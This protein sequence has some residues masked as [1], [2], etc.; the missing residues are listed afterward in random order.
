MDKLYKS[1]SNSPILKYILTIF[2]HR[3]QFFYLKALVPLTQYLTIILQGMLD[4][5]RH[6]RSKNRLQIYRMKRAATTVHA[7]I[8]HHRVIRIEEQSAE[9]F[10]QLRSRR[11]SSDSRGS[12]PSRLLRSA[13]LSD[14]PVSM[15]GVTL[16]TPSACT[17]S[18]LDGRASSTSNRTSK[19]AMASPC[20]TR[21]TIS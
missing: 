11:V 7:I 5:T 3:L 21:I 16:G 14:Q 4:S 2:L 13:G 10:D 9:L 19:L 8:Y 20:S 15:T 12:C 17:S 6:P 18:A 1:C